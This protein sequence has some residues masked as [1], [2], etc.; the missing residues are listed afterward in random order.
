MTGKL[1]LG[2]NHPHIL[3]NTHP[4]PSGCH[5]YYRRPLV[6]PGV[7]SLCT[8]QLCSV[9]SPA[10][11]V[12]HVLV[13]RTAKVLPSCAHWRHCVP[14]VLLRVV[15]FHWEG[16]RSGT[17]R[18]GDENEMTWK[19]NWLLSI[20]YCNKQWTNNL[21]ERQLRLTCGPVN[22]TLSGNIFLHFKA[23]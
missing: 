8:A 1:K 23:D 12:N 20:N 15:A 9:I 13:D 22:N 16:E 3:T 4:A 21:V 18:R 17:K 7:V 6:G 10:N 5:S 19:R 2:K 14:A 11:R